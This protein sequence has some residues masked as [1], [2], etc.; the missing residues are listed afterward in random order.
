MKY[1]LCPRC[2]SQ[3][4]PDPKGSSNVSVCPGC[5]MTCIFSPNNE[6]PPDY[7]IIIIGYLVW[8]GWDGICS[9]DDYDFPTPLPFD[10][11]EDMIKMALVFS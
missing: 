3:W 2:N 5:T 11:T 6:M 8:W 1:D 9:I 4:K 7:Y 10:I